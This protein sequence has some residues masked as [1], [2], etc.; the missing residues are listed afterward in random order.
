LSVGCSRKGLL[1][2]GDNVSPPKV[3]FQVEK[4]DL[5]LT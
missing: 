4:I 3:D 2:R 1:V 5:V